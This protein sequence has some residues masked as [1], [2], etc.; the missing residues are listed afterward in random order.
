[1]NRYGEETFNKLHQICLAYVFHTT[2]AMAFSV[3]YTHIQNRSN[4]EDLC[5]LVNI[6]EFGKFIFNEN[7]SVTIY[8]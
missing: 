3:Y 5:D 4:T 6:I 1:M 8:A 7:V 2:N